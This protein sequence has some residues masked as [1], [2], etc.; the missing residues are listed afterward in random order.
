M[1]VDIVVRNPEIVAAKPTKGKEEE[2]NGEG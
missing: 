1:L 2:E